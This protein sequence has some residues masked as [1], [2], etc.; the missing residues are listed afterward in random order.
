MTSA[1]RRVRATTSAGDE[2]EAAWSAAVP[3]SRKR[4]ASADV[5]GERAVKRTRSP[6][7][8]AV[9]R[10]PTVTSAGEEQEAAR[11][12]EVPTS[13]KRAASADANGERVA[14]RTWSP[15]L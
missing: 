6:R 14:K 13:R 8:S 15:R 4:A 1:E 12:A 7:P 5:V 3:T 9:H 11:R 10:D 2:Q